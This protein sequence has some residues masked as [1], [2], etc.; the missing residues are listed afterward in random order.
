LSSAEDF[1]QSVIAPKNV[2]EQKFLFPNR[3]RFGR[4]G[5]F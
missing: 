2:A 5:S 3:R 4:V 1:Y